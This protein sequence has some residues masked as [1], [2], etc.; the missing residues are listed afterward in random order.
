[1]Q[2]AYIIDAV[3]TPRGR[4]RH[5]GALARFSPLWLTQAVLR[6]LRERNQLAADDP[7]DIIFGVVESVD[8][9]G[10]NLARVA[11]L[12]AGFS[13]VVPAMQLNRFCGSGLEAVNLAAAKIM[14]GQADMIIGGGVE[15][16]SLVPFLAEGGAFATDATTVGALN[17]VPQGISA[18]L[19]ATRNGFSRD[20]L[21][22]LA[23]KSHQN[24]A[25]AWEEGRFERGVIPV[26]DSNGRLGLARDE[27]VRADASV[28]AMAALK[29]AFEAMGVKGGFDR[30]AQQSYP[31]MDALRHDHTA[32]NSSAIVDGAAAVLL[33][34]ANACERIGLKPRAVLRAFAQVGIDPTE[35]LTG[36]PQAV[37]LAARRAGIT[38]DDIGLVEV[39]EAFAAVPLHFMR[40]TGIGVERINVNGGA[41]AMGHPLGA[42]GAML[43]GTL[44]DEMER[45]GTRFGAVALCVGLGMSV[46]AIV[47]RMP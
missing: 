43:L 20:V 3:R 40:D 26:L 25:R 14:A 34:S 22:A 33:A 21:D 32:G 13:S 18:D 36:S 42:S 17:F 9:Q 7:E 1:M 15:C 45:S 35:M 27:N 31:E 23:V 47:E 10:G 28:S 44:V 24:A 19:I 37:R 38:L 46:A 2:A 6:A 8:D 4:G 16:M 41:I 5:D 11:A 29:P 12:Q 30:L 39:N